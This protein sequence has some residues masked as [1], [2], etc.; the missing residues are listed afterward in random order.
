MLRFPRSVMR[1]VALLAVS[2]A[3]GFVTVPGSRLRIVGNG[4]LSSIHG[5]G[6]VWQTSKTCDF[7][8]GCDTKCG[9]GQNPGNWTCP[10][11][12]ETRARYT[13]LTTYTICQNTSDGLTECGFTT[14]VT[15]GF[16][17]VCAEDC[18]M[19]SPIGAIKPIPS[20]CNVSSASN[21]T[22]DTNRAS[23]DYCF[24]GS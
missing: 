17:E 21:Q 13:D 15:C 9:D 10:V 2:A 18:T 6:C 12:G 22:Y 8:T 4:S 19:G 7:G 5:G 20:I 24:I 14:Q 23:G 16:N 11:S 3:I 1:F